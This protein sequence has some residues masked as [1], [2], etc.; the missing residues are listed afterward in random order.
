MKIVLYLLIPA[1]WF[2]AIA[3]TVVVREWFN[4]PVYQDFQSFILGVS[5][6]FPSVAIACT[7]ILWQLIKKMSEPQ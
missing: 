5:V 6:L 4:T 7:Y 2:W 3:L 1:I